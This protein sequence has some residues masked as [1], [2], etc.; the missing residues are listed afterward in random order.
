MFAKRLID[1]REQKNLLQKD[2]ASIFNIDQAA[3]SNWEN[4]KRI[5]DS[6][7]LI[8]LAKFFDVSVD[9]LLG[10][11]NSNT[12][13]VEELREKE[14]LKKALQRNGFMHEKK[15]LTDEELDKLMKFIIANKE[16]LIDK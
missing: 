8:K 13:K 15:D 12:N 5:P 10:F 9:Y 3:V 14:T 1:L 7:M 4:G 2:L 16:F 6:E 11:D